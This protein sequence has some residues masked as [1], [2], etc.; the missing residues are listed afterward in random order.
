MNSIAQLVL[1]CSLV[2]GVVACGSTGWKADVSVLGTVRE[3][4]RDGKTES[5][6]ELA[7]LRG[8]PTL[9]AVGALAGLEGEYTIDRGEL[10]ITRVA[11]GDVTTEHGSGAS[12]G[13]A[14]VLSAHVSE[15]SEY[16]V[17]ANVDPVDLPD[18]LRSAAVAHGL[19]PSQP[20][21]FLVSG[22]LSH[23]EAHVIAGD[24]PMRARMLGRAVDPP[25]F[26]VSETAIEARI[27][28]FYAEGRAGEI[29]HHG[30]KVHAHVL[31][32]G[33]QPITAHVESVGLRRGAVLRLP[34]R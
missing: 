10:W 21:P 28:G 33:G 27:V 15:W 30:A 25:P 8:D 17:D 13:A 9:V 1:V 5:R 6:A 29:T 18:Y 16:P 4:L 23:I 20:F 32:E 7:D 2:A 19:D 12:G 24:C 34:A 31:L 3:V 26:E 14:I 11:E 22:P